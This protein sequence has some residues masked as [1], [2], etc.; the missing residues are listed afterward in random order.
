MK[1]KAEDEKAEVLQK[2]N[3][4]KAAVAKGDSNNKVNNSWTPED[5]QI[6]LKAYNMFPPGTCQRFVSWF[7]CWIGYCF[8]LL[9][10]ID[11]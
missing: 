4:K 3:E 10:V 7:C 1:K 5:L 6:L 8:V 11:E 2:A 9:S